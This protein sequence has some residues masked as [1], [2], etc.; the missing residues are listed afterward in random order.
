LKSVATKGDLDQILREC[1]IASD[2]SPLDAY[3][4]I[5]GSITG[6]GPAFGTKFLYFMSPK[7]HRAPI[8]DAVVANWL[9]RFGIRNP[10]G[11]FVSPVGWN[12]SHYA[13]YLDIC[14]AACKRLSIVD[15]GL[16]EYLMFVDQQLFEWQKSGK[17]FPNWLHT[18]DTVG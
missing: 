12:S 6:L 2:L 3:K 11:K 15:A 18:I 9:Y 16:I 8:F 17:A 13:L 4:A 1:T 10:K 5:S 7:E 14:Q